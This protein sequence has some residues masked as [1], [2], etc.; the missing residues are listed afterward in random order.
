MVK[1]ILLIGASIP[2]IM[3]ILIAVPMIT[4]PQIP[5]TAANTDDQINIE[6][7]KHNLKKISF[8]VTDRLVPQKTEILTISN[9]GAARYL[10]TLDGAP[11]PEK[12]LTL[13]RD[14][15]RKLTALVKETGFM[16][17]PIDSILAG[18]QKTEYAKF[19]LKVTLNGNTR[20]IQWVEQNA[21]STLIPPILTHVES[22]LDDVLQKASSQ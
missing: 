3:A 4:N 16:H 6:F 1:P 13:E 20:Q 11:Q 22:N 7:T 12:T 10:V 2:V 18:D 14:E 15:M 9:N 8:G 21:T 5:F 17:L 19:S